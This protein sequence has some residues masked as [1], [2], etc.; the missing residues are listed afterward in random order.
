MKQ[1]TPEQKLQRVSIEKYGTYEIAA[2]EKHKILTKY[3][4]VKIVRRSGE[5]YDVIAYRAVEP[6]KKP[7]K[8]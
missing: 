6:V 1:T 5:T 7:A 2:R 4:K 3:A 8:K